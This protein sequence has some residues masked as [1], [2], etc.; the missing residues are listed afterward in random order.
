MPNELSAYVAIFIVAG[1]TFG[2]RL[3]GP[4]IMQSVGSS[5]RVERFL[6]SLSVSVIAAIVATVIARGSYRETA[7]VAV[8]ATVMGASKSAIWAMIAGMIFAAAWTA[9]II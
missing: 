6:E 1:V 5:V 2:A 9:I 8:A 3:F 7:A 4:L